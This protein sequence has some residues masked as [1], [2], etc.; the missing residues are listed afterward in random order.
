MVSTHPVHQRMVSPP[1]CGSSPYPCRSLTY[2]TSIQYHGIPRLS[3]PVLIFRG[4]AAFPVGCFVH[5]ASR[6]SRRGRGLA[7]GQNSPFHVFARRAESVRFCDTLGKLSQK[8]HPGPPPS[9]R[10]PAL[11]HRPAVGQ[12]R[13]RR[14]RGIE[15]AGAGAGG[16]AAGGGGR[17]AVVAAP[18]RFPARGEPPPLLGINLTWETRQSRPSRWKRPAA[19]HWLPLR[20]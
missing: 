20:S 6:L 15:G 3:T 7:A 13:S 10:P 16:G 19:S 14:R 5:I 8:I 1:F 12:R 9:P 17:G 4:P 18:R 2:Q 11:T